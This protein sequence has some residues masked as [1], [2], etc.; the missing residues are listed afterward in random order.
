[1][2]QPERKLGVQRQTTTVQPATLCGRYRELHRCG[3]LCGKI[4]YR[5]MTIVVLQLNAVANKRAGI[6]E[7]KH[8]LC[9]LPCKYSSN[10]ACVYLKLRHIAKGIQH[11]HAG[12]GCQQKGQHITQTQV[13][14]DI[15]KQ[16]QHQHKS[17]GKPL[18]RGQDVDAPLVEHHRAGF[19]RTAEGPV[20]KV[21]SEF[22]EHVSVW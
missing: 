13:V 5:V 19:Y 4:E 21:V 16:H 11:A 17:K 3:L 8:K 22:V 14:I 1:M 2:K 15:P 12:D 10:M 18:P 6:V 9:L 7:V 20:A